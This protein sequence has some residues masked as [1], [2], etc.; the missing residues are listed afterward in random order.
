MAGVLIKTIPVRVQVSDEQTVMDFLKKQQEDAASELENSNVALTDIKRYAGLTGGS[1]LL[2]SLVV[3]ENYPVQDSADAL[4]FSFE[5]VSGD[6]KTEYPITLA[7]GAHDGMSVRIMYD[8][9]YMQD[10]HANMLLDKIDKLLTTIAA[11]V[12]DTSPAGKSLAELDSILLEKD[13]L[14]L[15]E[16]NK[17][18]LPQH[19]L[20][21]TAFENWAL[22]SPDSVAVE[23][24]DQTV[25]Y[26]ELDIRANHVATLLRSMGVIPGVNVGMV[27]S[28]STEMVVGALAILK[29]GGAYVPID[30]T[31]PQER[32]AMI[33]DDADVKIV[34]TL[35]KHRETLS[36]LSP[37][38]IVIH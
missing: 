35:S 37:S 22:R 30:V 4:P 23:E 34:L 2:Q 1:S 8:R 24:E 17:G 10:E 36:F 7:F 16:Q 26:S 9:T 27:I 11:S 6:E 20:L 14:G 5:A 28:R 19:P 15:F 31:F 32:V 38:P 18:S 25:S 33:M 29:A 12:K 21:H 3:Y 13:S